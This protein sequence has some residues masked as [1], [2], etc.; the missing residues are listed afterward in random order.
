MV[1]IRCRFLKILKI[2]CNISKYSPYNFAVISKPLIL[3]RL[4]LLLP[5]LNWKIKDIVP[6]QKK[7]EHVDISFGFSS[8]KCYFV[9]NSIRKILWGWYHKNA[10]YL[11]YNMWSLVNWFSKLK[12]KMLL[13]QIQTR[14]VIEFKKPKASYR[15]SPWNKWNTT[16]IILT[17]YRIQAVGIL[18]VYPCNGLICFCTNGA[19]CI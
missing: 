10:D 9:K 12:K 4:T 8:W 13:R 5:I 19:E 6:L 15:R 17:S 18:I 1:P 14:K 3:L 16:A 11:I 2:Y 7:I